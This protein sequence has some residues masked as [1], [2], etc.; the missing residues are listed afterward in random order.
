M[1]KLLSADFTFSKFSFAMLLSPL[2]KTFW[3]TEKMYSFTIMSILGIFLTAIFTSHSLS[4]SLPPFIVAFYG[5]KGV[6]GL[7]VIIPSELL[8]AIHAYSIYNHLRHLPS[9][10]V[11]YFK[12]FCE[13]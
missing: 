5:A 8:F 2:K 6:S 11:H 3:G 9:L 12:N 4:M 7:S 10:I 1:I 13:M